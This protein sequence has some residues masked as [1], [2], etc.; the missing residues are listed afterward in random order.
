M[1]YSRP[2]RIPSEA[3]KSTEDHRDQPGASRG[4]VQPI[5][6]LYVRPR[7]DANKRRGLLDA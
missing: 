5:P 1:C 6:D 3:A 7:M 4:G 2:N